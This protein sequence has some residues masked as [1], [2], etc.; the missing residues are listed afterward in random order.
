MSC[1][2]FSSHYHGL[3][4]ASMS[5]G[6]T[7]DAAVRF[8]ERATWAFVG[9]GV[10]LRIARYAM[11]FPL[12]WDEAFV[13]VN[14]IRRDYL[15][16]LRPLDYGQVCPVLFLWAELTVVKLLGFSEWSL[17]LFP[18]ICALV[19]VGLF[20]HLAGRVMRG[21]PLLLAVAIFA[22][23]FHPIRHAADVKPYA[24]DLLAALGL[25]V[26]AFEWLRDRERA[27]GMWALAVLAPI[28]IALSHPSIFVAGGLALGLAP[29]VM[30]ARRRDVGIAY[31]TFVLSTAGVFLALYAAFT[32]AQAAAT[33]TL[34]QAQ[35][36]AAFPPVDDPVA[37]MRWLATVHTGS[38]FAYPCGGER[39]ASSLTL[40]VFAVGVVVLWCRRQ[41]TIVLAGLAPFGMALAAAALRR[42]PYGGVADGSPARVM[43]YLVP[44]ICLLAGLG[45]SAFLARITDPRLRLRVLRAGLVGLAAIGITPLVV[46][47]FHPFRAIHAQRA[48]Q[49]ARRFWPDFVRDAEPVCLRWDLGLGDWNSTNLNVAV[50]LCNQMIYSPQR[51]QHR[52]PRWES[53]SASRPLR[54]VLPLSDPAEPRVAAWLHA[55]EQGYHLRDRRTIVV[56]MAAPR[57]KPRTEKYVVYEFVPIEPTSAHRSLASDRHQFIEEFLVVF[58][59]AEDVLLILFGQDAAVLEQD[60]ERAQLP[61]V[62]GVSHSIEFVQDLVGGARM[63]REHLAR[64]C[65]VAAGHV[66][67][68]MRIGPMVDQVLNQLVAALLRRAVQCRDANRVRPIDI[69]PALDQELHRCEAVVVGGVEQC[70]FPLTVWTVN[71]TAVPIQDRRDEVG[72]PRRR[73]REQIDLCVVVEQPLNDFFG[74]LELPRTA[75]TGFHQSGPATVIESVHVGMIVE[76]NVDDV[77]VPRSRRKVQSGHAIRGGCPRQVRISLQQNLGVGRLAENRACENINHGS[78]LQQKV[79]G[80]LVAKSAAV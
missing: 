71:P 39:G 8:V 4:A 24:S 10:L 2:S 42:Y 5:T 36:G 45:A 78:M 18:L 23:S 32:R 64:P 41:R 3:P 60:A 53:V 75:M 25:L 27:G 54:C 13:A 61:T 35:W 43:Q 55:M 58:G 21:I 48:R 68:Q 51:R 34:M 30:K 44:S 80:L 62:N 16:L 6:P 79:D 69:R 72:P 20:R 22:V 47:A 1:S 33:L 63:V 7:P 17:R 65:L 73:G 66:A 19:S 76:E 28:A 50:Y 40:I 67:T 11:D 26:A 37:L 46:D 77:E 52:E 31:A 12:W 57:A 15:D 59:D 14:F 49:F 29:A 38:M 70:G 9:L 56:D 74:R